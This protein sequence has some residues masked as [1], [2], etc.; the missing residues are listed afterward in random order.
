MLHIANG[1]SL[2]SLIERAGIPGE[3]EVWADPLH[4]GPVPAVAPAALRAVR[5]AYL[6]DAAGGSSDREMLAALE[7]TQRVVEES[8]TQDEIVLW[9]EHDLF[10]QLNL[11]HLLDALQVGHHPHVSLVSINTFPGHPFFKGMGE[12]QSADIAALFTR[13]VPVTHAHYETASLAWSAFRAEDPRAIEAVLAGDTSA[14]PFLAAALRR[15]LE[16]F[17]STRNGLS[18]TEQRVASLVHEGINEIWEVFHQMHAG[19]TAFYIA[20]LSFRTCLRDFAATTP[21]LLQMELNTPYLQG[22]P[23][24][25]LRLTD[26]GLAVLSGAADRVQL[27]GI[28]RWLGGVRLEGEPPLWR[29]S[30]DLQRLVWC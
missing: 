20:D 23:H 30:P 13:R 7:S 1:H 4:E 29:W 9:Y 2:T 28:D 16:E 19:E 12:L 24:G 17:P 21:A 8:G 6:T 25:T 14:L 27:C 26:D 18:R 22:L 11:V 15:H 5:A 10:D 3:M